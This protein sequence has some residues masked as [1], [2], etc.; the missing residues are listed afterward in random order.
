MDTHITVQT[1]MLWFLRAVLLGVGC[2]VLFDLMRMLRALLPHGR[3]AVFL[4]DA[5]FSF[6]FCF[7]WQ[8]D[9]WS[10]CGGAL[11]WQHLPGMAA[12]LLL[13]LLTVGRVTARMLYR[14][15]QVRRGIRCLLRHCGG[16][17]RNLREKIYK[18]A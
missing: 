1:E 2:G 18:N 12:G 15:R 7:V 13:Y 6:V 9:A 11:R 5:V 14:L 10:F 8:V 4:E 16:R 3:I 17:L